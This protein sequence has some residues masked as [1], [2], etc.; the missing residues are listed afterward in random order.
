MGVRR[1]ATSAAAPSLAPPL[2]HDVIRLPGRPLDAGSRAYME[3][4]FGHSFADVRIHADGRA[5]ESAAAV[6]AQAYT[7]GRDVVF[8]AGMYDPATVEGRRLLAHE[9]AHVVQQQP[10]GA[11]ALQPALEIG[12]A[13]APEEREADAA[14]REIAGPARGSRSAP[15]RG[16]AR[17]RRQG[18][19][20]A[21][22]ATAPPFS[23]ALVQRYIDDA[24]RTAGGN[25]GAAFR[26][27]QARR[28]QQAN[29]NDLSLAAAEHYMFARSEVADPLGIP[30]PAMVVLILGYS[31]AKLI[32]IRFRAGD[33]PVTSPSGA[34]VRWA[35]SGATDGLAD[36]YTPA[37]P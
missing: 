19:S 10:A 37:G 27:L 22:A 11:A 32:G 34:Q 28:Q 2:V 9:L 36:Y 31:L 23:D 33:C 16:A 15:A 14:A 4:R 18:T 25:L 20:A 3:P 1:S 13:D 24:I 17:L 21:P 12:P 30:Y 5:A 8:G 29:C 6:H 7:V 35:L 26:D